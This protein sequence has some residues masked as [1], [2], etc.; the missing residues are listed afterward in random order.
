MPNFEHFDRLFIFFATGLGLL[1][2]GGVNLL[3]GRRVWLRTA[4]TL[5][6]CGAVLAGL[7][8]LARP[9]LVPASAGWLFG[10]LLIATLFGSAWVGRQ[11]AHVAGFL[12]KPGPRW[13]AVALG[14]L[15]V[16]IG[17]GVAFERADD[18]A[19]AQVMRDLEVELGRPPSRPVEG[20]R[21]TTDRG[22]PVVVREPIQPRELRELREAEEK[23]LRTGNH[24]GQVLRKAEPTDVSNCH[25]YVFTGGK[26]LL[27]PDEVEVILRENDYREITNPRPGD[28]VVYRDAGRAVTHT[29]VVEYASRGKPVMV[30]SKWGVMGVFQHHVDKSCYGTG[31]AYYRS[32]RQGHLLVGLGGESQPEPE[33][34]NE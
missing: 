23:T 24:H 34:A 28:L 10:A 4:A 12:R 5:A 7:S 19:T 17:S 3:L 31:F 14:G 22:T 30:E 1:L 20:I 27:S 11:L 21:V 33:I 29:A 32:A 8:A 6:V 25:G 16:I 18:Q 26:Y 13:A 9:E 2:T 15:G